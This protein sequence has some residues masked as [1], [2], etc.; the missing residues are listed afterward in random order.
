MGIMQVSIEFASSI[1]ILFILVFMSGIVFHLKNKK[2]E[3][4]SELKIESDKIIFLTPDRS[5]EFYLKITNE[6]N[7]D[8]DL[9]ILIDEETVPKGWSIHFLETN[10]LLKPKQSIKIEGY[11]STAEKIV[12]T[13]EKSIKLYIYSIDPD[14]RI[15]KT[16]LV[17]TSTHSIEGLE[18]WRTGWEN[19]IDYI[20][21]FHENLDQKV[22]ENLF[23]AYRVCENFVDI[24]Q[25]FSSEYSEVMLEEEKEEFMKKLKHCCSV[26]DE[27]IKTSEHSSNF[28]D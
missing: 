1:L 20:N 13:N 17:R 22:S 28:H 5:A 14:H 4:N 3:K 9:Y 2:Q 8:K 15:D 18:K 10:F 11:L 27:N 25:E 26:I 21:N 12:G 7:Y 24:Y 19:L 23:G 6:S 16:I